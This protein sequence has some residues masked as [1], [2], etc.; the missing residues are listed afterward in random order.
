MLG[1]SFPTRRSSDLSF[2]RLLRINQHSAI[3]ID[4]DR[5]KKDAPLNA[6]KLRV[7]QE[8][9]AA[10][11]LCWISDGREIENYLSSEAVADAYAELSGS[12]TDSKLR[13]F[14]DIESCLEKSFRKTWP[15]ANYYDQSKPQIARRIA[16]HL[17]KE[18]IG[19]D[20]TAWMEK[21]VRVIRHQD[22]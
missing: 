5:R 11:V 10:K 6:T 13:L 22:P 18:T 14:D 16:P 3:L 20:L 1:H 19:A 4:S 8:S 7:Q 12:K 15:R 17:S 2:I 9:E 21:L